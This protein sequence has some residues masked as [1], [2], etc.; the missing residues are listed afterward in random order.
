MKMYL[1]APSAAWLIFPY[2]KTIMFIQ[3]KAGWLPLYCVHTVFFLCLCCTESKEEKKIINN[4]VVCM[5]SRCLCI[6]FILVHQPN[7]N[8]PTYGLLSPSAFSFSNRF[9]FCSV[10]CFF[11]YYVGR[12]C[13]CA[14]VSV[15]LQFG[16]ADK[17][18][19]CCL[20]RKNL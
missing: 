15:L 13:V 7:R 16:R 12:F 19:F 8:K 18:L 6:Y 4:T 1:V 14:L 10:V 20:K 2:M 9:W 5:Y 3:C 11:L 17:R